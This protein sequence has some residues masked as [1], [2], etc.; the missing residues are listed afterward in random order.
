MG[1]FMS[2]RRLAVTAGALLLAGQ[3]LLPSAHAEDPPV[4]VHGPYAAVADLAFDGAAD[5][6]DYH[7]TPAFTPKV[8]A[9][10]GGEPTLGD[11]SFKYVAERGF[12]VGPQVEYRLDEMT[13][14][15]DLTSLTVDVR[16]ASPDLGTTGVVA[17]MYETSPGQIWYGV[18]PVPAVPI[19]QWRTIDAT[20][21]VLSWRRND[22]PVS[23]QTT[24]KQFVLDHGP[25]LNSERKARVGILYGCN[26]TNFYAD[27]L[28]IGIA[29]EV[30]TWD[31]EGARTRVSVRPVL[32]ADHVYTYLKPA[33]LK[34]SFSSPDQVPSS[35]LRQELTHITCK[36]E[37][38]VRRTY[39]NDADT[40]KIR[41]W[42]Y[43]AWSEWVYFPGAP[44]LEASP[45]PDVIEWKVRPFVVASVNNQH[46][47]RGQT[48]VVTGKIAPCHEGRKVAFQRKVDGHWRTL[49]TTRATGC[50]TDKKSP[51]STYKLS[52]KLK[53]AGTWTWRVALD[54]K[55]PWKPGFSRDF[56]QKV[57]APVTHNPPPPPPDDG[58]TPPTYTPPPPADPIPHG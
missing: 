19:G 44:G 51:Y 21:L 14:L 37:R 48:L 45:L 58:Y 3:V 6:V 46:P 54:S 39:D 12:A 24:I 36:Q 41:A 49:K 53:T 52:V 22:E 1:D 27:N 15:R 2:T 4:V 31:L 56:R 34:V 10:D 20:N 13:K 23:L 35:V 25:G 8:N 57:T 17:A 9:S 47:K 26:G 7:E 30:T 29:D 50:R 32:G 43:A 16:S 28:R 40:M 55:Q 5:C 33:Y 42:P 38:C 18:A 11:R